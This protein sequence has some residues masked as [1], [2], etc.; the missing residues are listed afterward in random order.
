MSIATEISEALQ[1]GRA[2]LMML[3]GKGIEVIDLGVDVSPEQFV[4]AAIDNQC[5]IIASSALLTTTMAVMGEVV[6][7][8]KAAGIRDKVKIMVGGAPVTAQFCRS[9]GAAAYTSDAAT[10]ANIVTSFS[11]KIF[12]FCKFERE[13]SWGRFTLFAYF[14]SLSIPFKQKGKGGRV[15]PRFSKAALFAFVIATL[16]GSCLHFVHDLFPSPV[17]ALFSPVN[18][19]LWE[20]LKILFWPYL[21]SILLLSHLGERASLYP[22]LIALPI[23]SA[24]MLMIGYLFHITF[25]ADSLAFDIILYVL[26]MAAGFFLPRPLK[27]PLSRRLQILIFA[28][29]SALGVFI[30]LFTFFPPHTLLFTDL[31][32]PVT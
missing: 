12:I 9:I 25:Q 15:M 4:Q 32:V 19:S 7:Q 24:L 2:K 11:P 3:E 13:T 8:A 29:V 21:V 5:G 6:E 27:R 30:L 22:R 18:E 10:T 17:T 1:K 23:L 26:L 20:H 28:I 14:L 31:S 16:A